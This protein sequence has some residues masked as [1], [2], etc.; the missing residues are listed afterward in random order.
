M[1][2]NVDH[3]IR[4]IDPTRAD[5]DTTERAWLVAVR[6]GDVSAFEAMFRAYAPRLASFVWTYL[7]SQEEAEEVV[8]DLFLWIWE[9]RFEWEVPGSIRTYLFRSATNRALSRLRHRRVERTFR[10]R[11]TRESGGLEP[12]EPRS[13][14]DGLTEQDLARA[15]EEAIRVLPERC[16]TVFM[17]NRQQHLSYA[18][19]AELLGISPRTVEVHMGRALTLLRARLGDWTADS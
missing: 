15:V 14:T 16:R 12:S 18:E 1:D 13:A 6:I 2:A 19:I 9:H 7:Q 17:M 8:Q 3:K 4:P 11:V 10:D 5:R